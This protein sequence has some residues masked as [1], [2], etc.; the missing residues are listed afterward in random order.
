MSERT[1]NGFKAGA[2]EVI[3]VA[4]I[5]GYQVLWVQ[6]ATTRREIVVTPKGRKITVSEP[7][8]PVATKGSDS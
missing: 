7:L 5:D 2:A 1:P 8:P 3:C 4:A 6:T